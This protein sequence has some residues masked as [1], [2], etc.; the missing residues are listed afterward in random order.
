MR[1]SEILVLRPSNMV[2]I[3]V[4]LAFLTKDLCEVLFKMKNLVTLKR[5]DDTCFVS[6]NSGNF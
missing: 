3:E 6:I 5:L 2:N 4:F 1:S